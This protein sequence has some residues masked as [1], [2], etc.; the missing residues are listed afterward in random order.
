MK[1]KFKKVT[2]KNFLAVGNDPMEI[3][4]D[5]NDMTLFCGI[6]GGG[7]CLDPSTKIDVL[8]DDS[9]AEILFNEF[10]KNR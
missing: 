10:M 2:Y 7:K 1:V 9:V 6:N 5:C 4:L 8:I 3:I